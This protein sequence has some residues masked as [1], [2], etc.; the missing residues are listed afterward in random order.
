M[1]RVISQGDTF[2]CYREI[3]ELVLVLARQLCDGVLTSAV[4]IAQ[5]DIGRRRDTRPG[6]T[7]A[8]IA[9]RLDWDIQAAR[10]FGVC[11]PINANLSN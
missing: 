10:P 11:E 7:D 9:H 3:V 8:R 6:A 2:G 1:R 4:A 5:S